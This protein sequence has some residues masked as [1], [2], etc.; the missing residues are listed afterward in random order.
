ML[1]CWGESQTLSSATPRHGQ[2]LPH[3]VVQMK[4]VMPV[5]SYIIIICCCVYEIELEELFWVTK[6]GNGRRILTS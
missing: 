5:I 6:G 4:T 3:C 2:S 1:I